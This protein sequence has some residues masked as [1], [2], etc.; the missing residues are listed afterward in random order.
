EPA[1]SNAGALGVNVLS[2]PTARAA[3]LTARRSGA[4]AA[5]GGFR[6]T[7]SPDEEAGIVVYQALYDGPVSSEAEREARF[8]G[9]VFVTVRAEVML[10]GL[11]EAAQ[12]SVQWCVVDPE[13]TSTRWHIAGPPGCEGGASDTG[14][15]ATRPLHLAGHRFE[16]RMRAADAPV[17][18]R[19]STLLLSLAALMAAAMLGALLLLITG[20]SRRTELA[21]QAATTELRREM[22]ERTQAREALRD[23]EA[24]LRTI[25]DHAPIGVMFVDPQGL[26]LDCNAHLCEML[27]QTPEQLRGRSFDEFSHPQALATLPGTFASAA[28]VE[29]P[30]GQRQMRL[31]RGDGRTLWVHV[32]SAALRD[33]Q[34]RA[35]R[36]VGVVQ[37]ITERVRLEESQRALQRAEASSRA[38]S[39]FVS[40]MSHELRTPLNAMIGFA[41]LLGLDRDP[42]LLAHQR[43]WTQQIQRA[44]WHL[45]EMINETL[46]L[47]RIE[48]GAV[49]L[50]LKPVALVPVVGAAQAMVS[51]AAAQ[52][53]VNISV[54]LAADAGAVLADVTRLKQVMTNL[55]SN[56][57]KYN[58]QGGTV[59]VSTRLVAGGWVEIAV[60]D[61]GLGMTAEQLS[62]LF[63]PYNRLGR[64]ASGIEGTGIGLVISRRLAELMGGTLE[65]GSVAG[66]GST[67]SL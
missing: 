4:P 38:K 14:F 37:D 21:V 16:L 9:V 12:S 2:I 6:L 44:G 17:P 3:L 41:Q 49:K 30:R 39:E 34:G 35:G 45:L 67:F 28:L 51:S 25:L 65:A 8:R 61:S 47:A 33:A 20:H 40:R 43:E 15:A 57:V 48:S 50:A 63:Q 59:T 5:S 31:V 54:T 46:D 64:E 10:A 58:R 52:R 62:A 53:G 22:D 26:L 19:G 24:R 36:R 60:A 56:A 18:L 55:L 11:A 29:G 13:P 1:E 32:T 23:S 42:G 27:G 66:Q 7:Q